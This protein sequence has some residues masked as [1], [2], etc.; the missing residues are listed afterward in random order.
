[1]HD[2]GICLWTVDLES[3]KIVPYSQSVRLYGNIP[4]DFEDDEGLLDTIKNHCN[5]HPDYIEAHLNVYKK[6]LKGERKLSLIS[7][8]KNLRTDQ[9]DWLKFN[10]TL[11][12]NKQNK[13]SKILVNAIN[14]T[15]L[16][17][18]KEKYRLFRN[19]SLISKHHT[20]AA[21]YFNLSQDMCTNKDYQKEVDIN[22][23]DISSVN[24]FFESLANHF[25]LKERIPDFLRTYNREN[26]IN[27]CRNGHSAFNC[28]QKL[29]INS[30]IPK[31]YFF[32]IDIMENPDTH[33]VE[34]I[35]YIRD[36]D[37]KITLNQTVNKLIQSDYE[38]IGLID[39]KTG[40][41]TNY[42][43]RLRSINT[44]NEAHDYEEDVI[45]GMKNFILPSYYEECV[46][47]LSLKTV[48]K[49]LEKKE[50]YM[51]KFPTNLGNQWRLWKFSY[52]D[53]S[54][55]TIF[56]TR[57][58][59]TSVIQ[60]ELKQKDLLS[61][62]LD[63]ARHAGEIKSQLL[64]KMSH[65]IR[66]P[67]NAIMGMVKLA[68]IYSD[69]KSYVEKNL[70]EIEDS[71]KYLLRLITDVLEMSKIEN[72]KTI[73]KEQKFCLQNLVDSINSLFIVQ[74]KEKHINY[75]CVFLNETEKCYL[76]DSLRIQQILI[77]IIGNAFKFTPE[78]GSIEFAI[79]QEKVTKKNALLRITIKDTGIGISN[80]FVPNLFKAF[81]QEQVG[82]VSSSSGTGLGLAIS[83]NL[84]DLMG[85][86]IYVDSTPGIGT[87]F[88]LLLKLKTCKVPKKSEEIEPNNKI[89]PKYNLAG[90]K[91]LLCEDHELNIEVAK[92]LLES[93]N[94]R[95]DVARDG[96]QGFTLFEKMNNNYYDAI[97]MD[98]S[99]PIMD[100]Y[101]ATKL[102]RLLDKEY[103]KTIPIIA[104]SANAF[105]EDVEKSLLAGMNCHIAK[106][107]DPDFLFKTL[108]KYINGNS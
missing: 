14:V 29:T 102:I 98:I 91:V 21:F 48:S 12:V 38:L 96:Q 108:D 25:A 43:N 95:V 1:M 107:F 65:E 24:L 73:I 22:L 94:I 66:T 60:A 16:I 69:N 76:G 92:K 55:S 57:S 84:I 49:A 52:L 40:L 26:L 71:G 61:V 19:Y 86:S 10:Y 31:W 28:E 54:K 46:K 17:K 68:L 44:R 97:I 81:E 2:A 101:E 106:P 67:L 75:S 51:C 103:A 77:N 47:S 50:I 85:G 8:R 7:K 63:Q 104:M 100:G 105:D 93:Q 37:Q 23:F 64:S 13:P 41:F 79:K 80:D 72:G 33:N 15:E 42:G 74:A 70:L 36:I 87:K 62:A 4:V 53:S 35:F 58:N 32:A 6:L 20:L 3:K 90:K 78:N 27:E 34:A 9:W 88:T 83:K 59:I 11:I 56:F 82:L 89:L 18:T 39:T 5:I 45:E 99:M 30:Q